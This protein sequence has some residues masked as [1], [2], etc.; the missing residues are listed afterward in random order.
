MEKSLSVRRATLESTRHLLERALQRGDTTA[1]AASI[2]DLC[3]NGQAF[4]V[5][6]K[7]QDPI[8]AYV[9][10]VHEHAKARVCWVMAAGGGMAGIDLTE[11]L[12]GTIEAQ[13][14]EVQADQIAI[15]TRRRGLIK[16]LQAQGFEVAGVTL[17]KKL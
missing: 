3:G 6:D 13:A 17:R 15:T 2:A 1:G 14:G 9:L 12:M 5:L 10:A 4:E 7:F 11:T 16:K 8:A